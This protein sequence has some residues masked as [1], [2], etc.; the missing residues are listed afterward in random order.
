MADLQGYIGQCMLGSRRLLGQCLLGSPAFFPPLSATCSP[1]LPDL[2]RPYPLLFIDFPFGPL[3]L[4]PFL[5]SWVFLLVAQS[6]ATCSRWFLAREF[7]LPWRW[8]RYVPPKHRFTQDLHSATTQ[9]TVFF[10]VTTVKTSNP[11]QC[12]WCFKICLFS[13]DSFVS[14]ATGYR[15]DGQSSIPGKGKRFFFIPHSIQTSCGSHPVSYTVGTKALSFGVKQLGH[16]AD[17]STPS[18]AE[19]KNSWAIPSLPNSSLWH[20]T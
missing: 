17:H 5:Y 4:P 10:I 2:Y 9:K 8:R 15:L 20:D 6:A 18:S 1:G 11:T 7:F 12:M 13:R 3:S 14:K 16:E 19:A